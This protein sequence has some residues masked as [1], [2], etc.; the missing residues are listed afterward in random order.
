VPLIQFGFDKIAVNSVDAELEWCAAEAIADA[1]KHFG[2]P[3]TA[4]EMRPIG[5]LMR[6]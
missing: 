3:A 6:L 4:A 2:H 5:T 1:E